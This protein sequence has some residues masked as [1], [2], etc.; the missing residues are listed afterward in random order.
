MLSEEALTIVAWALRVVLPCVL[1]WVSF[2]PKVW[3]PWNFR[4]RHSR[5]TLLEHRT[6]VLA[7]GA[8]VPKTLANLIMVSEETAPL[9]FQESRTVDRDRPSKELRRERRKQASMM[10]MDL[11][12]EDEVM[13]AQQ[14][15]SQEQM[16][17]ESLVNFVAFSHREQRRTFLRSDDSAPP[18]PPPPRKRMP[19]GNDSNP[20][21]GSNVSKEAIARANTEAQMVL[22]GSLHVGPRGTAVAQALHQQLTTFSLEILPGTWELMVEACISAGKLEDASDFLLK[23]EDASQAPN[24]VL[25][26]RVMEMYLTHREQNPVAEA[27]APEPISASVAEERQQ[28]KSVE[29]GVSGLLDQQALV[30][31]WGSSATPSPDLTAGMY[32]PWTGMAEL[33]VEP[34]VSKVATPVWHDM[35]DP[36]PLHGHMCDVSSWQGAC[37]HSVMT[38]SIEPSGCDHSLLP[39][40]SVPEEFAVTHGNFS[41]VEAEVEPAASDLTS[42]AEL[43]GANSKLDDLEDSGNAPDSVLHPDGLPAASTLSADAAEFV[44]QVTSAQSRSLQPQV[45]APVSFGGACAGP[46]SSLGPPMSQEQAS[47]PSVPGKGARRMPPASEL[48][49]EFESQPAADADSTHHYVPDDAAGAAVR[50]SPGQ[51]GEGCCE[52]GGPARRGFAPDEGRAG[53]TNGW[54]AEGFAENQA[55]ATRSCWADVHAVREDSCSD[56]SRSSS[57]GRGERRSRRDNNN[58]ENLRWATEEQA[59]DSWEEEEQ[60]DDAREEQ[61]H[62]QPSQHRVTA[63]RRAEG[64][65]RGGPRTGGRPAARSAAWE[66]RG[67]GRYHRYVETTNV[68]SRS[69]RWYHRSVETADVESRSDRWY[70]RSVET[71]HVESRSDRWYH[72][73]VEAEHK[74]HWKW[75]GPVNAR[76]QAAGADPMD[77]LNSNSKQMA[78]NAWKWPSSRS[79]ARQSDGA[80]RQPGGSGDSMARPRFQRPVKRH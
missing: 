29:P 26:D 56:H 34:N 43:E 47:F 49:G 68:E 25:L 77:K 50:Q 32:T 24:T 39:V 18:P 12:K 58:D 13:Q 42:N 48:W 78:S 15:A 61:E 52:G 54:S 23:M 6:A 30:P 5:G 60:A 53:Y 7:S 38:G 16:H 14:V 22:R 69:D 8:E 4:Y 76:Y 59:D 80:S 17:M 73:S 19:G 44:P 72:R 21:N 71:A 46:A 35:Q 36:G 65:R 64:Y 40:F 2:G 41:T 66:P 51:G 20:S 62:E 9:L 75:Q 55:T 28:C 11:Q 3:L 31:I 79:A 67:D 27:A 57:S 70:H 33:V 45:S 1:F 10:K 37:P 63:F 74:P